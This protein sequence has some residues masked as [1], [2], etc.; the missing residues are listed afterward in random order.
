VTWQKKY[1][2]KLWD[3][4]NYE[5]LLKY[6]TLVSKWFSLFWYVVYW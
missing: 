6:M 1:F 4:R 3:S 5:A 2:N